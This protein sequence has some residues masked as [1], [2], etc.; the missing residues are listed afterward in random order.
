MPCAK[1]RVERKIIYVGVPGSV[2][3][4]TVRIPL[5]VGS[6]LISSR[7][8]SIVDEGNLKKLLRKSETHDLA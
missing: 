3:K 1:G 6:P 8:M 2:L 7:Y 4:S 5:L